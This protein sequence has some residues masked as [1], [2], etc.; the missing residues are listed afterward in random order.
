LNSLY[1]LRLALLSSVCALSVLASDRAAAQSSTAQSGA[2]NLPPVVVNEPNRPRRAANTAVRPSRATRSAA[3]PRAAR[4]A[5]RADVVVPGVSGQTQSAF[6]HVDGYVA[7]N[8]STGMKGDV[9]IMRTPQSISVVTSDQ[10][11]EQGAQ[12]INEALRYTAGVRTEV[13]GAQTMDNS[14]N[15]R[16]FNQGSLDTFQDGLRSVTPGYFGFFAPEPYGLER[17]EALKGPASVL[18]GQQVPGG[19]INMV[20]KRPSATPINEIEQ[21]FGS[22]NY[23]QTA[24]DLGGTNADKSVMYR[25]VGLGRNADTQVDYVKNDRTYLAPSVTWAPTTDTKITVLASYQRNEGDVYANVPATAVLLPNSNGHIP[26]S[27]FLGEPN[28]EGET[29]ERTTLG[30][31]LEHRFNEAVKFEQNFR[32]THLTNHRQYLQASGALVNERTLNRRYTLRDIDNDGVALDNRMR[33]DFGTGPIE[34]KAI[35]GLDYLWGKSNW[36]EQVGAATSIDIFN[37]VYGAAVNTNASTSRTL[38]GITASQ[39]GLYVQDQLKLDKWLL[40]LGL[41]QDWASRTTDNLIANT[42]SA[43]DDQDLTKRAGLMYLSEIGLSPYVS[44]AE[45]FTPLVGTDRLLKAFVPETGQQYEV[46]VKYQPAGINGFV[47]LSIFDLRRQNVQTADPVDTNYYVQT[48]EVRV[49]GLEVEAVA[50]LQQ[51][52]NLTA[53]YTYNNAE[54]TKTNTAGQLG[55]T[56]YR[57][58]VNTASLWL[59][60]EFQS[61]V[62]AGIGLGGGVRY[63][64]ETWGDD[65]NTFKVPEFTLVDL[66]FRYD[67]GKRF[68]ELKGFTASV[69]VTNLF[70]KYYVPACF[71]INACNYG[72]ART[73]LG[74]LAYRW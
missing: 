37:P 39:V 12:S 71:T 13:S 67:L 43:Q 21:T 56:P 68:A 30:Y 34:H 73:V 46:G 32:Y 55:N 38:Q 27:R 20:S 5:R 50:S 23:L 65:A 52:L 6:R 19:L 61:S 11:R 41:R 14:L 15:L 33:L 62:L 3:K 17:L 57:V 58:P 72:S 7:Q 16:G 35:V 48:G 1:S 36:L 8:A 54:I 64:G 28:W 49:K 42:S 26:F 18:Y 59:N 10:I 2:Q 69:N 47:T 53:A 29:S 70:D 40:T 45:S 22:F 66:A 74:K 4:T 60:Y 44:Y 25:F 24:F 51:G 31:E 63:I 9:P